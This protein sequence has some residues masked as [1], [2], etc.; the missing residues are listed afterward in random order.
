M[1]NRNY[2]I[3]KIM[4][5]AGTN[6]PVPATPN[7]FKTSLFKIGNDIYAH[8]CFYMF[9]NVDITIIQ[10]A[11]CLFKIIETNFPD[12]LYLQ[13]FVSLP[14]SDGKRYAPPIWLNPGAS[15]T[16]II[17]QTNELFSYQIPA[18]KNVFTYK[19]IIPCDAFYIEMKNNNAADITF[20]II[21]RSY[22][23]V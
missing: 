13:P 16:D 21:M 3:Q 7:S 10:G 23:T 17:R 6:P 20:K 12:P 19:M 22:E 1:N 18:G 14:P 9:R 4:E 5:A 2:S 15:E 8:G 11:G